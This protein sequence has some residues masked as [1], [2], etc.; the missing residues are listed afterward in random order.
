MKKKEYAKPEMKVVLLAH[1]QHLL[2]GSVEMNYYT[3]EVDE[4]DIL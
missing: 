3:E 4:E 1:Q 2:A